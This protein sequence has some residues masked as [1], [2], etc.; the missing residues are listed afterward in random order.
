MQVNSSILVILVIACFLGIKAIPVSVI[1]QEI[2]KLPPGWPYI[3]NLCGEMGTTCQTA[4]DCCTSYPCGY[5]GDYGDTSNRCCG[6]ESAIGCT[7]VPGTYGKGCCSGYY[8]AYTD[9]TEEKT[10]CNVF[11]TK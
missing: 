10:M 5:A 3:F 6:Q 7:V 11:L 8:C 1:D 9:S 2:I 4:S